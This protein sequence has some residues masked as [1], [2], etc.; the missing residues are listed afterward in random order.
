MLLSRSKCQFVLNRQIQN[1][2]ASEFMEKVK[3][4]RNQSSTRFAMHHVKT[5][6][7]YRSLRFEWSEAPRLWTYSRYFKSKAPRKKCR[8]T[9]REPEGR[10]EKV[11]HQLLATLVAMF[12]LVGWL[13]A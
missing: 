13:T 5:H 6:V 8:G 7:N 4:V 1:V 3:S 9:Q 11:P 2:G 12:S 10:T